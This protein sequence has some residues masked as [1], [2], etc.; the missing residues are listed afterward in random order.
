MRE[1]AS[2]S[3]A[4]RAAM[5]TRHCGYDGQDASLMGTDRHWI[6]LANPAEMGGELVSG[7]RGERGCGSG[8]CGW[9]SSRRS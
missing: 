4:A 7:A 5:V 3:W 1:I 9:V 2:F 6:F 8:L